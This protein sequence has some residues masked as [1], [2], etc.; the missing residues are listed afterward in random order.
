MS[1]SSQSLSALDVSKRSW[2][3]I[4]RSEA[5]NNDGHSLRL[6]LPESALGCCG[7]AVG[8]A[9][10]KDAAFPVSAR[11]VG[12]DE[13]LRAF[14]ARAPTLG[15]RDAAVGSLRAGDAS[16]ALRSRAQQRSLRLRLEAVQPPDR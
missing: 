11:A 13:V 6:A 2:R 16:T 5:V 10:E 3:W 1:I 4:Y 12:K 7:G 9:A 8:Q 15:Q 14:M